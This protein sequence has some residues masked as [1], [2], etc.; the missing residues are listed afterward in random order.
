MDIVVQTTQALA[1]A[2]AVYIIHRDIKPENVMI[3]SDGIVKVLDFG[4]AKL[5][6]AAPL[7]QRLKRDTWG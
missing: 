7:M 5:V 6:E 1:A 2:H 4:L 3:R